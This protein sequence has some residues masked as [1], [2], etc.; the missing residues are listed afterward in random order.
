MVKI[1]PAPDSPAVCFCFY[2]LFS[3]A[4][5]P[6]DQFDQLFS[7][8]YGRLYCIIVV[9]CSYISDKQDAINVIVF[10]PLFTLF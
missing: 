10:L 1:E 4:E 2:H 7:V 8:Q 6:V 5:L 3:F 9:Q